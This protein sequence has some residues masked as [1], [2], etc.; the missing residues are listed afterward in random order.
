MIKRRC[1][2]G[3]T[4]LAIGFA[5]T[6]FAVAPTAIAS[7]VLTMDVYSAEYQII[8]SDEGQRIEMEGFGYLTVPG[9][10]MLPAKNFLIALPPGARVESIEVESFGA[11]EL[12]GTYRIAA[13]PQIMPLVD[14]RQFPELV[15]KT[16]KEWRLNNGFV[17]S[18]DNAY[19]E[20]RGELTAS[21]TL[22][23]YS[24][25]SVSFYPFS[26]HP[27]SGRLIHYDAGRIIINYDL[28]SSGSVEARRVEESKRD[29][30]ADDRAS[31]L[32]VNFE[33]V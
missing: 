27:R 26:Y 21:G 13:A 10:P 33:E 6:V 29:N 22:R 19:P 2:E 16:R 5:L 17:Y 23:K 30:L 25:A 4:I 12:P 1:L 14:A 18:S 7:N 3:A 15:E 32:F 20:K 9:K 8:D 11:T 28:P 31:R 24:Y